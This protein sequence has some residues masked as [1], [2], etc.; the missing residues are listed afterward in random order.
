M[1]TW[2]KRSFITIS[3]LALIITNVLTLTHAAFNAAL[4]GLIGAATGIQTVTELLQTKIASKDKVIKKQVAANKTR[5]VAARKFGT[6]LASRT[7]RVAASSIA[8]IPAESV[9]ILGVSI[10]IAGTAYELWEACQ[11]L[12]DLDDMYLEM[13]IEN[14][15]PNGVL[16]TVCNP[17]LIFSDEDSEVSRYDEEDS[18]SDKIAVSQQLAE[19]LLALEQE[20]Y[21]K[22]LDLLMPLAENGDVTAQSHV[23]IIYDNGHGV[24]EDNYEAVQWYRRAAMQGDSFAQSMLGHLYFTQYL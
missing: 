12:H 21:T 15:T 20:Q 22:S 23:A 16:Q 6:R 10:L 9:P 4:S 11:S 19:G 3:F 7:K 17:S 5:K 1:L 24:Q 13:G 14:Q 2:I 18:A 8:A